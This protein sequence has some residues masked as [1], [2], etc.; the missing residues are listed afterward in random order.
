MSILNYYPYE[1][2]RIGHKSTLLTIEEQWNNFDV[3]LI[4]A[5]VACGKT[6]LRRAVA[7]W[8]GDVN[9]T[10]PTNN[11]IDQELAEFPYTFSIK[12]KSYY[13]DM[14]KY[15]D[16]LTGIKRRGHPSLLVPHAMI[17]HKV[18]KDTLIA[19]EGHKL[20]SLNRE[21]QSSHILRSKVAFPYNIWDRSSLE[22]WL[23]NEATFENKDKYLKMLLTNDFMIKREKIKIRGAYQDAIQFIPMNPPF[24]YMLAAGSKKVILL[25]A[26]LD[27]IDVEDLGIARDKRILKIEVPSPIPKEN[28]PIIR[29]FVGNLNY[30][31]LSSMA[32]A[33]ASK[34]KFHASSRGG[35]GIVHVT[36][37]LS[38]IL[39]QYLPK[40][41]YIFHTQA[42]SKEKFEEWLN[43]DSDM[44]FIAAGY[45]EGI[46]LI[47]DEFT[48]QIIAKINWPSMTETVIRKKMSLDPNWYIWQVLR[49]VIQ[50]YGRICRSPT[51]K[52]VTIILDGTFD[53]L[54]ND[55]LKLG[56]L[57]KFF[58]E[59]L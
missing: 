25:S 39:E 26:T 32:P 52:G 38:K 36:Y 53:R 56:L 58:K 18:R 14:K 29:D 54:V 12:G 43:V 2:F 57:P 9:M 42:N 55:G 19:D 30:S 1:T 7:Y 10:V 47:G 44:V 37:G 31:N 35:K 46:N 3:I 16:D 51:D 34:I 41:K 59:V 45:S 24:S 13:A 6:G 28:R 23:K 11:L 5:S 20:V 17:A 33:I 27:Q 4:V 48:W 21:L 22:T 40:D 50:A 15:Y 8:A 49:E